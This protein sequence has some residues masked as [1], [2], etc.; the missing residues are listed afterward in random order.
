MELVE[1]IN[2]VTF[3][4]MICSNN[5]HQSFILIKFLN[6]NKNREE[7]TDWLKNINFFSSS[8]STIKNKK[9]QS[10]CVEEYKFF[11]NSQNLSLE[12]EKETIIA[13]TEEI[14]ESYRFYCSLF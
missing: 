6:E 9:K 1:P 4:Q 2:H 3:E 10:D 7:E 12:T 14:G 5:L 8:K 13:T 11:S